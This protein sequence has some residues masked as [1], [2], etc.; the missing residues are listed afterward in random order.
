MKKI[1]QSKTVWFNVVTLIVVFATFFGYTPNQD[2][3]EQATTILIAL[4][5]LINLVLRFV[6]DKAIALK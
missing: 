5:P 6:T 2:L 1:Y 3:A 4:S